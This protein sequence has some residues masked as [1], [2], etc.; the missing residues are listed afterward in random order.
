MA[1]IITAT[2]ASGL[3]QQ[4]DNSGVL[5]LASGTGNLVTVPSATGTMALTASPTFTGTATIP[6][7][8][9]T[10]LNAPSGV[11]A[12]QNGMTGIAKAWVNYN[13]NSQTITGSFNVSSVT[14]NGTGAYTINFTTA[15]PNANYGASVSVSSVPGT[16]D[17]N[18]ITTDCNNTSLSAPTTTTFS[19]TVFRY[20]G[21]P[22]DAN[23]V[24]ATIFSS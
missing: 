18:F 12:T 20:Q 21:S 5:Q 7:A 14:R 15:M 4:A 10:T 11:L 17:A 8:T 19:M 23:Y 13:G 3:T 6:T 16:S 22:I 9:V 24:R 2:V 1:S